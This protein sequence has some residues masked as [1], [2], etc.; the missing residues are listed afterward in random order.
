[1][2]RISASCD[3]LV[4][5]RDVPARLHH[6]LVASGQPASWM[7]F[8]HGIYGSGANWRT[9][10]RR[11]VERRP[12][13]GI[14]L[15]DLR[16]HGRSDHGEPPQS[17]EACAD[18]VRELAVQLP[19]VAAVGGHSFGGKVA[20]AA[21]AHVMLAQTW[22]FDAS[23]SARPDVLRDGASTVVRVLDAMDALP[24]TFARR[25]DFVE[26]ITAAGVG[27]AIAQWLAM[28]VTTDG[29]GAFALRFDLAQLR[30]LLADYYGRD[31]W[32]TLDD[33]SRGDVELVIAERSNAVDMTDRARLAHAP[34][35][36]HV[37]R[38]DADHWLNVEA[39]AAV[40]DLLVARLP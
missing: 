29:R 19:N 33:P 13:W 20:L 7:V 40:V 2:V 21:R 31:L 5:H 22:V 18:D 6:D 8:A 10:A 3:L 17:L 28:S 34:P 16:G 38:I 15:V 24:R 14:A 4:H 32:A 9:I 39:P 30:E 12:T 37:H 25:E 26:Q 23:P 11:V 27:S 35:H 36:V 1:V